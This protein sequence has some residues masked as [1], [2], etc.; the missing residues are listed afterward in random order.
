MTSTHE[1]DDPN[2]AGA[3]PEDTPETT[4]G[5]DPS[6]RI[7][8]FEAKR[9]AIDAADDLLDHHIEGV[10]EVNDTNDGHWRIVLEIVE[11]EAVP[12]T[13]DILGRYEFTVERSGTLAGYSL[14]ERYRRGDSK[15][16]L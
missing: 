4:A 5:D 8:L 7:G 6:Q 2:A 13:Q 3:E 11:R 16:E 10:I 1:A 14:V 9:T 12:D 15:D